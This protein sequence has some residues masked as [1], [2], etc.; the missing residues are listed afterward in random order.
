MIAPAAQSYI[1]QNHA[2]SES[3]L[4]EDSDR[5]VERSASKGKR[6]IILHA[7]TKDGPLGNADSGMTWGKNNK[8]DTPHPGEGV[9]DETAETLWVSAS[10]SG[11]Y[12][13]NMNALM[14]Q[15]W[16]EKRLAP[17]FRRLYPDKKMIPCLDNAAYHH[18]RGV[19]SLSTITTKQKMLDLI[20]EKTPLF[21]HL[22]LPAKPGTRETATAYEIK[23]EW[24]TLK[25][26]KARPSIPGSDELKEAWLAAVKGHETYKELLECKIE[27]YLIKE[28][29]I[30]DETM[31]IGEVDDH[32]TKPLRLIG[33]LW[34]PPYTPTLQPIEEFWAGGKN[35]AASK[36]TNGRKVRECIEQLRVGWY[37]D[38]KGKEKFKCASVV[39]RSM[40][41]ADRRMKEVGGL[42][43]SVF[44][45]VTVAADAKTLSPDRM[46]TDMSHRHIEAVDLTREDPPDT[47]EQEPLELG[48]EAHLGDMMEALLAG[49]AELT[50]Q[51]E[52]EPTEPTEPSSSPAAA[53][54]RR[55]AGAQQGVGRPRAL[56]DELD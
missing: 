12:H 32:P 19:D 43:G 37:G 50:E 5:H 13:D 30:T 38:G 42:S 14:Y 31:P 27:N 7:I 10:S 29:A 33:F 54:R 46:A 41:D 15:Q 17:T 56:G 55:S 4:K 28:I 36:Y 48:E 8:S 40:E 16:I 1:H 44:N 47:E 26:G 9:I 23:D 35:Y 34:T 21:T 6:V 45:G 11:D 52:H 51:D 2:P 53:A 3:W 18:N 22:T 39:R 25:A 24:A 49:T 20:R